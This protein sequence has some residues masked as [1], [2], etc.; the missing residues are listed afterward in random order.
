M[1]AATRARFAIEIRHWAAAGWA[2]Q[3]EA[4]LKLGA[5]HPVGTADEWA[6]FE[7]SK[8]IRPRCSRTPCSDATKAD[9]WPGTW[10]LTGSKGP[11]ISRVRPSPMV[12]SGT[13]F[14]GS[15]PLSKDSAGEGC[16][17]G[18]WMEGHHDTH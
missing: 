6:L 17:S 1:D 2:L 14:V 16:G 10:P 4:M 5:V 15:G 11:T 12:V 9:R 18:R 3:R 7:A 8:A 13:R